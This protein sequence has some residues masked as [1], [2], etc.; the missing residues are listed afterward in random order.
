MSNMLINMSVNIISSNTCVAA[1]FD[2]MLLQSWK[3]V[4]Q[5]TV[6]F[7]IAVL[8]IGVVKQLL[9]KNLNHNVDRISW[10][11]WFHFPSSTYDSD[12]YH[13][14][15]LTGWCLSSSHNYIVS[16]SWKQKQK[17]KPSTMLVRPPLG[18][19]LMLATTTIYNKRQKC[20]LWKCTSSIWAPIFIAVQTHFTPPHLIHEPL[21]P[22]NVIVCF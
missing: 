19:L 4:G 18:Y 3:F 6:A 15:V 8:I 5:L 1:A 22:A 13:Y 12:A 17:N 20:I 9:Q 11:N 2:N 21:P 7:P 16:S 14:P 10:K